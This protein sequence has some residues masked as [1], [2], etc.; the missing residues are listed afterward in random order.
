MIFS[1]LINNCTSSRP[2]WIR[3]DVLWQIWGM[4]PY[5][6]YSRMHDD[7]YLQSS[8]SLQYLDAEIQ[9]LIAHFQST[10]DTYVS[11][12]HIFAFICKC[13]WNIGTHTNVTPAPFFSGGKYQFCYW[14]IYILWCC[15]YY[16]LFAISY[17]QTTYDSKAILLFLA[18]LQNL[19]PE[20]Q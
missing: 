16:C 1:H 10:S 5:K 11:S 17:W 9:R 3:C 6:M 4:E 2:R 15:R 19:P 13:C 7:Y 20:W 12:S 14:M 18:G 8:L